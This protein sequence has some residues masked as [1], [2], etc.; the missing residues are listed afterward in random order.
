V[1]LARL[2]IDGAWLALALA[3]IGFGM[4]GMARHGLFWHGLASLAGLAG[5][6]RRGM[7]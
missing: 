4:A 3:W 7:A 5:S 2:G 1:V 6:V